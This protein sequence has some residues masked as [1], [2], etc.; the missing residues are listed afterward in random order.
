MTLR[1]L[2]PIIDPLLNGAGKLN[3]ATQSSMVWIAKAIGTDGGGVRISHHWGIAAEN[4]ARAWLGSGTLKNGGLGMAGGNARLAMAGNIVAYTVVLTVVAAPI[5]VDLL[6]V[7][8]PKPAP[9]PI[10]TCENCQEALPNAVGDG[11]AVDAPVKCP[12]CGHLR[13]DQE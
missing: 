1:V 8:K 3:S 5:V 4:A 2:P 12:H 10:A 11:G 7:R 13:P 6:E 9:A